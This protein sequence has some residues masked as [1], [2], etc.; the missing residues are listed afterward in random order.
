MAQRETDPI[1]RLLLDHGWITAEQLAT[2]LNR[3]QVLGGRLGT[4]LLEM[5]AVSE[6]L[7]V[8]TLAEQ[9]ALPLADIDEL[10]AIPQEVID[11]LPAKVAIRHRVVPFRAGRGRVALAVQ[12]EP[13]IPILDELAFVLGRRAVIHIANE[14]RIH[15]ALERHYGHECP[16]RFSQLL[17][18]L[19]RS[20]DQRGLEPTEEAPAPAA[21]AAAPPAAAAQRRARTVALGGPQ[22]HAAAPPPPAARPTSVPLSP[23][24]MKSLRRPRGD[25]RIKPLSQDGAQRA[26]QAARSAEDIGHAMLGFLGQEFLRLLV[27][28]VGKGRVRG[29]MGRSPALD[30]YGFRNW[31]VGFDEPSVFLNL[32]QGAEFFLGRLPAMPAHQRLLK[33]WRGALDTECAVFPVKVRSRLVCAVYGD[34][35]SLGLAGLDVQ[36]IQRL[37]GKAAIAFEMLLMQRKLRS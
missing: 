5:G 11:L 30:E 32:R 1:G 20:R 35:D 21:A 36:S 25:D 24:E 33:C 27:F 22:A 9:S 4:S 12:Q 19:N 2:A 16:L 15:E 7:L 14:A 34:R 28:R 8:K 23:D 37:T 31:A 6:D 13:E 26:L 29:W 18:G 10:R 3:Q 17:D